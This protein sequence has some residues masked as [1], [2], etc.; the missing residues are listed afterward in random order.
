MLLRYFKINFI[1]NSDN[2]LFI[3]ARSFGSSSFSLRFKL[4]CSIVMLVGW[5]GL[6]RKRSRFTYIGSERVLGKSSWC[7]ELVPRI[8]VLSVDFRSLGGCRIEVSI[9]LLLSSH[10]DNC[11]LYPNRLH[12]TSFD[13]CLSLTDLSY[14]YFQHFKGYRSPIRLIPF[15]HTSRFLL[16]SLGLVYINT[17]AWDHKRSFATALPVNKPWHRAR[18]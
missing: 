9:E 13:A 18:R 7:C 15:K 3:G 4:L 1:K 10:G 12:V 16:C 14:P 8:D 6:V 2:L 11:V 17:T 5:F